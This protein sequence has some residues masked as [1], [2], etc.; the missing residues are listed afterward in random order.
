MPVRRL[1]RLILHAYRGGYRRDLGRDMEETFTSDA[2]SEGRASRMA[3][4]TY[5]RTSLGQRAYHR[6]HRLAKRSLSAE[7]R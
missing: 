1:Y 3:V 5:G 2:A 4:L 6:L 7:I